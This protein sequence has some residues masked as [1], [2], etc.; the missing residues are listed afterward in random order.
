MLASVTKTSGEINLWGI[1][2]VVIGASIFFALDNIVRYK[3]GGVQHESNQ[4]FD[5]KTFVFW[6][7]FWLS[8][9]GTLLISAIAAKQGYFL[10]LWR[11]I[12]NIWP[13][14]LPFAIAT[15]IGNYIFQLLFQ[16]ALAMGAEK[17]SK[18][19]MLFMLQ[20]VFGIVISGIVYLI[21]PTAFG[22][23]FPADLSVWIT[24]FIGMSFIIVGVLLVGKTRLG[25][26]IMVGDQETT[27]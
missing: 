13:I 21:V 11:F 27:S 25:I 17:V 26:R 18:I 14:L 22:K 2:L 24:R 16:R 9:S 4:R 10:E 1:I 19:T 23:D 15:V 8:L 5:D 6:R 20:I 12:S 3:I 7:A